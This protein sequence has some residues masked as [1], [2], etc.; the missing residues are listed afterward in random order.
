[1]HETQQRV[2]S[3]EFAE[4]MAYER[5]NG[6]LGQHRMDQLFAMLM[7]HLAN[8]APRDEKDKRQ[9]EPKDFLPQWDTEADTAPDPATLRDKALGIFGVLRDAIKQRPGKAKQ[10]TS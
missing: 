1:M 5:V 10:G 3:R 8:I 9:F 4:W 7:A 2:S 6:P